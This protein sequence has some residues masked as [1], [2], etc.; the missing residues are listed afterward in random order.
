MKKK[1]AIIGTGI[2]G[3]GA[4]YFLSKEYDLTLFEKENYTGGHTNTV[5]VLE[6]GKEI[7]IDTGFIVFN[8]VT[9]PNLLR[10]FD[11]LGVP[12]KKSD[13]SFSVQYDPTKLEFCGSGLNGLFAQKKNFF[14]L[15]FVKMLL[16]INRF[17]ETAP[18]ILE[19]P[20]YDHWDLREY[21]KENGYGEDILDYYLIPMSSAVWTTPP[22]LILSFPVKSL[23]RFFYNHGFL[24]LNSQHQ[25]WTV[26]GGSREYVKLITKDFSDRIRVNSG[27]KQVLRENGK[28]RVVLENGSSEIFDK[29]ILATH[30]H[31]SAKLLGDPTHLER[32]LLP[33]FTYQKNTVTLHT[34]ESDMPKKKLCWSSWN[35]KIIKDKDGNRK[36]FTIYWMNRL[37][38]VSK[39]QNYFVTINDPGRIKK[40]DI[41]REVEYEHPLFSVE[42][43]KAQKRF[44]KLNEEGPIYYAGAYS[45][46][47]FHE[48][49]FLSAVNVAESIL[50]R[51][52]WK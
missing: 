26:D 33:L 4:A 37:Q 46:Y 10:L 18:Q 51:D 47:G 24:G 36:P 48:D 41:I 15:Q 7:P 40:E 19:N 38:N 42:N 22:G 44:P 5:D 14:N 1:L 21:M 17:N 8:H 6:N 31:T 30:G 28:V 32:E 2:S 12:T 50:K 52:P 27:I 25:W 11:R 20:K 29:A 23:V 16:E 39:N 45:G 13:M 34:D 9:Y 35:Y 43:A 3:L 49:G